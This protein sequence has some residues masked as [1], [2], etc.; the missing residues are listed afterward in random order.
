MIFQRMQADRILEQERDQR[1]YE[2]SMDNLLSTMDIEQIREPSDSTWSDMKSSPEFSQLSLRRSLSFS[3]N[4]K[5]SFKEASTDST[6]LK[7]TS[8]VSQY[9]QT[10]A[11]KRN[12]SAA[13]PNNRV[14]QLT[15]LPTNERRK[16]AQQLN[17]IIERSKKTP[18][19]RH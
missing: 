17:D 12:R 19:W 14:K 2:L 1:L 16:F 15:Q 6:S 8:L 13:N 3:S 10:V 7:H 5:K 11:T 9:T 18:I 4:P